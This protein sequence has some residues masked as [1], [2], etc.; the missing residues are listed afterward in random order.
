MKM[1]LQRPSQLR[2]PF[3]RSLYVSLAVG[4]SLAFLLVWQLICALRIA[5]PLFLPTPIAVGT[6]VA[7]ALWNE[8]WTGDILIS[9]YRIALG[10]VL[11]AAV[12]I[13]C[14]LLVGTFKWFEAL[15]EPMN[16]FIRYMPVVAF[17]PLCILWVGTGD[18]EKLII[19]FLGTYFQLMLLVAAAS[20]RVQ[21]EYV[22]NYLLLGGS[23]L[24]SLWRVILPASW[25]EIFEGLRISA[26]WA[27]SYLVVAELVDSERGIG[28]KI[29]Q[30]QRFLETPKVIGGIVI[31]GLF[32]LAT[33][34]L[35]KRTSQLLF[36][37][38]Q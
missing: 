32:G 19:V 9:C 23:S 31:V 28:F 21:R 7:H 37:W 16:D 33:D 17:I 18:V 15:L 3:S 10:F 6:A 26:G 30:S 8:G 11:S 4:S 2:A 36:S 22:E 24:G 20:A 38:N 5:P 25:P 13:P 29:L 14:G 27:W 1:E 12:A 34:Y 35:F